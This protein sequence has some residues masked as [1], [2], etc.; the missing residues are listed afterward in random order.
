M[1]QIILRDYQNDAVFNTRQ[2]LARDKR[3][4]LQ[5]EVGSGKT[6][7]SAE[8]MRLVTEK[9]KR[10]LFIAPRRQLIYQTI[11]TLQ[12]FNLSCGVIM[13][14]E[15]RFSMPKI[16][17]A[18]I[19][20]LT[21]RISAG[22]M[23]LPDADLLIFDEAHLGMTP[24]RIKILSNYPY[25]IGLT[26]TPALANGKGMGEFYNHIVEGPNMAWM[27]DNN[28]LVPMRYF[29]GE[30]PD[31]SGFKLD[32]NGD[33][34][35]K[36]LETAN[37][38]KTL[39][40]AVYD[41]W[42]KIAGKRTTLVFAVNRKHA[43]HLHDEFSAHGV[44]TD[45][46]DGETPQEDRER[47]KSDVMEGRTQVIFNVGVMVAGV[48]W[49]RISCIV[50][51]RQTRNI[52]T[53][54]Q[55]IGR[56]SRLYDEKLDCKVIYHGSNFE[57]LG[58]MDDPIEWSLDDSTTVRE[59]KQKAQQEYKEPKDIKCK[60]GYVFR[61]SRV[62]PSCGLAMIAESEAIPFHQAELKE[63]TN[64]PTPL[65]KTDF[66]SQLLWYTEHKGFKRG[67]ADH[68]FK[69]KFGHYPEKKNGIALTPPGKEVLGF[70]QHLNIKRAYAKS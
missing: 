42:K 46:I 66:Y 20:T 16:Q 51:A 38:E 27:V 17:V 44:T 55:I 19:D 56:G 18:S 11:E 6:I 52:S 14:G 47:I 62:C 65:E 15:N 50:I 58:R 60:C 57:E 59:R 26:A 45:Y 21:A 25:V 10:V 30:A 2:A 63:V 36:D 28:Y 1:T 7:I 41:N 24:S 43:R 31:L 61:S 13:A 33:W 54:R 68:K 34:S 64:K 35:E 12:K 29:I 32:K 8:I 69:E 22:R 4:I 48:D 37:D 67:Y 3:V 49:P 9:M 23:E 70:I 53:W 40:G 39:I 5:L